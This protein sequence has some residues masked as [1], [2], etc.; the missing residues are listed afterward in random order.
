[1]VSEKVNLGFC[2]VEVGIGSH[3][4]MLYEEE[5]ELLD[6][7][8]KFFVTGLK[9]NEFCIFLYPREELAKKIEEKIGLEKSLKEK[10]MH[11]IYYKNFYFKGNRF[12]KKNAY[13]LIK[14]A[15]DEIIVKG[16]KLLRG[17]SEMSWVI[18]TNLFK[19]VVN[20]E[21]EITEKFSDSKVLFVCAYPVRSLSTPDLIDIIQSHM[22]LIYKKG[23]KWCVS[24]TVER[25][26]LKGKIEDLEKFY[27]IAIKREL[28]LKKLKEKIKKAG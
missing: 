18:N 9:N 21:N 1:M 14:N 4:V 2:P 11:F 5:G 12:S 16:L 20:F 10:R 17:A 24:E 26:I 19:K 25:K 28:E 22:M 15:L 8:S 23:R 3:M 27:K 13:I 6:A 7:L